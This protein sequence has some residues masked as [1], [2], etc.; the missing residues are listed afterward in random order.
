MS[1]EFDLYPV[2]EIISPFKE[3][4][5][6]PRQAGITLSVESKIRLSKEFSDEEFVRGLDNF[7]HIW[8]IFGFSKNISKGYKRL[9]RPPRLGGNKKVGVFASRS[10]FRPNFL[11]MSAVKLEKINIDVNT[12]LIIS[13][14]DF[15]NQT[16]VFDIKPYI[17]YA[18]AIDNANCGEFSLK[19]DKIFNVNFSNKALKVCNKYLKLKKNLE[20]ILSYDLRPGYYDESSDGRLFGIKFEC[21]DVRFEIYGN[22]LYVQEIV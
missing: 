16:P 13:G 12:E 18:D 21:Y 22:E 3:K 6:I 2:G 8:I 4:F 9:V 7:S 14:G 20:D 17:E 10:P 19:P 5:G 11:G 15:L 1:T